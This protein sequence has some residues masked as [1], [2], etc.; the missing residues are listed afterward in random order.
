[1]AVGITVVAV[2]MTTVTHAVR[3]HAIRT[4]N[5]SQSARPARNGARS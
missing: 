1:M 5:S 3:Q 2:T 4:T